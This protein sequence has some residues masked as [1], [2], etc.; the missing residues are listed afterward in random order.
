MGRIDA[1]PG[2]FPL[3]SL[4]GLAE[5]RRSP[6]AVAMMQSDGAIARGPALTIDSDRIHRSF[7]GPRS[8][9]HR[10]SASQHDGYRL[11]GIARC[12]PLRQLDA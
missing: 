8:D 1:L 6:L 3:G 12:F 9:I 11:G 2:G 4:S 10:A 7:T 5:F